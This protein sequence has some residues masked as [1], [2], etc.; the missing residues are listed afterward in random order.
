MSH[1]FIS[2]CWSPVPIWIYSN[3]GLCKAKNKMLFLDPTKFN[4]KPI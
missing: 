2:K 3:S 1:Y 4:I